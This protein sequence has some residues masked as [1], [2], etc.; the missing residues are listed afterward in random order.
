M[1]KKSSITIKAA[2][3]KTAQSGVHVALVSILLNGGA[4]IKK[5]N[6]RNRI[7]RCFLACWATNSE[8]AATRPEYHPYGG[9][10]ARYRCNTLCRK[11]LRHH[12]FSQTIGR[13]GSSQ[14]T[15]APKVVAGREKTALNFRRSVS[16]RVFCKRVGEYPAI[17]SRLA[18][19]L[20]LGQRTFNSLVQLV[21]AKH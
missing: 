3:R 20:A 17:R 6:Y 4:I 2:W 13:R 14:H 19:R 18:I 5:K 1:D 9:L 21:K 10:V 16:Q 7:S 11:M 15:N 12:V 8:V